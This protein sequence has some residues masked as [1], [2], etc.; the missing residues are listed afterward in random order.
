MAP[1]KATTKFNRNAAPPAAAD[2]VMQYTGMRT[3]LSN[4]SRH[5]GLVDIG[6]SEDEL[7]IDL[8]KRG[9]Q[10]DTGSKG[11]VAVA[12]NKNSITTGMTKE[13]KLALIAQLE[14][15]MKADEHSKP[16]VS[17]LKEHLHTAAKQHL[18]V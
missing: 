3:H 14:A 6:N 13:Q 16:P 5:S 1:F 18:S 15:S 17:T 9:G 7:D 4:Q 11:K 12:G 8:A 2:S 10:H